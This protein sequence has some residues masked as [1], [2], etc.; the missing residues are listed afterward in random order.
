MK[1]TRGLNLAQ[2]R[3]SKENIQ[4][5]EAGAIL[6]VY[7]IVLFVGAREEM[8]RLMRNTEAYNIAG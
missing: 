4:A 3:G 7:I 5:V 6:P 1:A 8:L 2:K